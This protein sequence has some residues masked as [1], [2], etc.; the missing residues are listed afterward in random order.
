[1]SKAYAA[2]SDQGHYQE[3]WSAS[4]ASA[5]AWWLAAHGFKSTIKPVM[6]ETGKSLQR[7]CDWMHL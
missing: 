4:E 3:F 7:R 1:M 6:I 2:F 5:L